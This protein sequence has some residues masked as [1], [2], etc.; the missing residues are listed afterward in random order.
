ML[1]IDVG[2]LVPCMLTALQCHQYFAGITRKAWKN[3]SKKALRQDLNERRLAENK[4][5]SLEIINVARRRH[6]GNVAFCI[7]RMEVWLRVEPRGSSA[8]SG[9]MLNLMGTRLGGA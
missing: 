1:C 4:N 6:R 9:K 5:L 7:K 3:G 8:A 2:V